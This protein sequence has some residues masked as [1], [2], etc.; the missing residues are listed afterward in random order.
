MFLTI[1]DSNI[2]QKTTNYSFMK[3]IYY[4]S[5]NFVFNKIHL[6]KYF[7]KS[8]LYFGKLVNQKYYPKNKYPNIS[9]LQSEILY[10]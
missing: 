9:D 10:Q 2:S 7:L 8:H 4:I 3:Y 5:N 6:H 1:A